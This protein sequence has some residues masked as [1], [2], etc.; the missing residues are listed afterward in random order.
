MVQPKYVNKQQILPG[1]RQC[2]DNCAILLLTIIATA[3][4]GNAE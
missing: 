1:H 3:T 2:D 4:V